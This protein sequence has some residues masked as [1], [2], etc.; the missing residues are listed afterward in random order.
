MVKP[1]TERPL[2]L[3][4]FC[5]FVIHI[6]ATLLIDVQ[7]LYPAWLVPRFISVLPEL[8]V[9]FSRDPLIGGVMGL[10]GSSENYNWFKTFLVLEL[11]FQLPVF[12]IAAR[13][14]LNNSKSIYLLMLIYAASTATTTLPCLAVIIQTP[15][16]SAETLA[17]NIVSI[18]TTERLM[19]LSSYLPFFLLP[20]GMTVDMAQR[21]T[22]LINAGISASETTGKVK[23][24]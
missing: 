21:L 12:V 2:D 8:Y 3:I 16:T 1:L 7:A 9:G 10:L 24:Q 4:Y 17:A 18:T 15:T 22:R 19:L 23:Q 5:F 13:G 11:C 14:L 20:L 6:P